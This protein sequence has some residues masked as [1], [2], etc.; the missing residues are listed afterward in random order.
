[1]QK[2]ILNMITGG[3]AQIASQTHM[4]FIHNIQTNVST[5]LVANTPQKAKSRILHVAHVFPER[6]LQPLAVDTL[7]ADAETWYHGRKLD[8]LR[9]QLVESVGFSFS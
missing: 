2:K 6:F 7:Y 4:W 8:Q 5:Y 3:C 9:A 1:M